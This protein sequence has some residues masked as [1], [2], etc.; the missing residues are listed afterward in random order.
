VLTALLILQVRRFAQPLLLRVWPREQLSLEP[1]ELFRAYS[2]S[3][4]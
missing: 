3:P 2:S 4:R 1:L